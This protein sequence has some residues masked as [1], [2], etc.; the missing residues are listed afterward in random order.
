MPRRN[1]FSTLV[2]RRK[3]G[4]K[5]LGSVTKDFTTERQRDKLFD[6]GVG[7]VPSPLYS[8]EVVQSESLTKSF[9]PLACVERSSACRPGL[10]T[11][12]DLTLLL[13]RVWTF[14]VLSLLNWPQESRRS[15]G[16]ENAACGVVHL[17]GPPGRGLIH[18][19][20]SEDGPDSNISGCD[21]FS[22]FL[23]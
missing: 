20:L 14:E 10:T 5:T 7:Q 3:P 18:L 8:L 17:S 21:E 16:S 15:D 13:G 22:W 4:G 12:P 19:L 9:V 1:P 23:G 11:S 6:E 2:F